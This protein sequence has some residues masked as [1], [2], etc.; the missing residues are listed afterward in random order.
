MT[1]LLP[2][3]IDTPVL[4]TARLILRAPQPA[5]LPAYTDYVT[6]PRTL[7]VG[8]PDTPTRAHERLC[9]M[10]GQWVMRGF[11]RWIM[12]DRATGASLGHVGPMQYD[13]ARAPELTWTLWPADAEGKG[14]ALEGALAARDHLFG[15]MG[16]P[17]ICAVIHHDN[18]RSIALA[19]KL[20]GTLDPEAPS[21]MA[22]GT[23]FRFTAGAAA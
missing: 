19:R 2:R 6:S 22:K 14:F 11:G 5:D 15:P 20:G 10:I 3:L 1:S 4:E 21:W 8:G 17:E 9:S 23:V 18:A 13:D 12:I 16:W 7:Y